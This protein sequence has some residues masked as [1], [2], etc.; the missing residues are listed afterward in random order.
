MSAVYNAVQKDGRAKI[1]H[2][3]RPPMLIVNQETLSELV[4]FEYQATV[5]DYFEE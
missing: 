2:R 5:E 3:D 4:D 1:V